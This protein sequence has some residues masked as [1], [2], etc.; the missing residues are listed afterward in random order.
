[1]SILTMKKPNEMREL[2]TQISSKNKQAISEKLSSLLST[3]YVLYHKTQSMH[4]NVTGPHFYSVHKITEDHYTEMSNAIDA[5]A[6]RIR[7]LGSLVPTG[8]SAYVQ[9]GTISPVFKAMSVEKQLSELAN[10]HAVFADEIRGV[11]NLADQYED[12]FTADFLTARI[13]FHEE[14]AWML[15]AQSK[16]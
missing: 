2:G 9:A 3:T 14:A 10:D 4:W 6:E 7:A 5:I 16:I 12:I 13:G 8:L 15:K 1:M 11:V